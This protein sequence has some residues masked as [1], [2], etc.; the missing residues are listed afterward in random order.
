MIPVRVRAFLAKE[1]GDVLRNDRPSAL[2]MLR[3]L[4]VDASTEF[5]EF[6]LT[7]Q[8]NFISPRAVAELLDI[9]GPQIPAIPDQTDYVRDRYRFPEKFLALTS[10]ESEGMYLFDREDGTVHDFDLCEYD[11]FVKGRVPARWRS[12]NAFLSWYFDEECNAP[13]QDPD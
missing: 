10:D 3:R 6:Y 9:E 7:Y 4:G 11:D 5:G 13:G 12:F 1:T 8:G 2:H